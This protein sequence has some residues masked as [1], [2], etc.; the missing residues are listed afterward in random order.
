MKMNKLKMYTILLLS[1]MLS[2]CSHA[3]TIYVDAVNGLT[4]G[5]GTIS[6]PLSSL[7]KAITMANGSTGKEPVNI[8][9]A[10]GLYVVSHELTIRTSADTNSASK[11]TIEAVHMPDDNDWK[12]A[13]MPVIQSVSPNNSNVQFIHTV[14]LRVAK[15]NVSIKGLKFVG[16]ASPDVA[17]YY[18]ITRENENLDG[19]EVSQC[20]FIGEKS[21]TRLQSGLWTHGAGIHVD[22]CIFYNCRCG[23]VLIKGIK[24]LSITNSIIY[25]AYETAIW[26]GKS[27][28]PFVFTNNIVSHC[29]FVWVRPKN[30]DPAYTFTNSLFTEN[31]GYMGYIANDLIP[32]PDNNVKE[33]NIKKNGTVNL[34]EIETQ[35]FQ[36]HNYLNPVAGSDG[37]DLHAGIFKK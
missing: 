24:D 21:S 7:E 14:C 11:F 1:S 28:E 27:A 12:P 37:S 19:L 15:N 18:P 8:K 5:D 10:A 20:Y 9:L 35:K 32:A 25:G 3:Q 22:H 6:N 34:L 31:K 17:Y 30:A 33:I 36:P 4:D 16:N 29:A 26:F 13:D 2:M 23:M